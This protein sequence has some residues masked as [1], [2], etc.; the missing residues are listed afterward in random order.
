MMAY[1]VIAEQSE[2]WNLRVPGSCSSGWYRCRR[3]WGPMANEITKVD[4]YRL[5]NEIAEQGRTLRSLVVYT[6]QAQQGSALRLVAEVSALIGVIVAIASES[7]RSA[8]AA[9]GATALV[10]I[11]FWLVAKHRPRY[12]QR[13]EQQ[14]TYKSDAS[15]EIDYWQA[16][17]LVS[18]THGLGVLLK[19]A[20]EI[21]EHDG[22]WRDAVDH[23]ERTCREQRTW[24]EDQREDV[25]AKLGSRYGPEN[26]QAL[27]E[28][29]LKN[30]ECPPAPQEPPS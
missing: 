28:Q 27:Y 4:V 16:R 19:L 10:F 21:H 29:M 15:H 26:A 30:V 11:L 6:L 17:E 2:T 25:L 18:D 3:T 7:I 14:L 22:T 5:L 8:G 12:L 24:L 13:L 9:L 23:W 1:I 20:R